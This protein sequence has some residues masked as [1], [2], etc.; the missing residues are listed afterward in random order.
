MKLGGITPNEIG[1]QQKA[2]IL[3]TLKG[4]NYLI[5]GKLQADILSHCIR[6]IPT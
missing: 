5:Y 2:T 6:N 4:L 3:L 1:G